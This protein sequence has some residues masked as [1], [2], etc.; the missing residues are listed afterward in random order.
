MEKVCI[1]ASRLTSTTNRNG[2]VRNI[3]FDNLKRKTGESWFISGITINALTFTYDAVS[4]TSNCTMGPPQRPRI[5]PWITR[6]S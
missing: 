2:L 4:T 5:E 1:A 6:D 3:S